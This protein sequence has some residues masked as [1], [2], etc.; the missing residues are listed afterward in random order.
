MPEESGIKSEIIQK[1]EHPYAYFYN[2]GLE[3]SGVAVGDID[4]DGLPDLFLAS[5]PGGNRLYRQISPLKFE[6][7]TQGS[8]LEKDNAWGRGASLVDILPGELAADL[9]AKLDATLEVAA[10]MKAK[11]DGGEMAYDQMLG[12][13]NDEGNAVLQA[14]ID[15]L[16][17]QTKSIETA[18][19]A[20]ELGS[21]D[22]EGSD[23]LDDPEAV[24][25]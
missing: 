3:A 25:Q 16:V 6:D 17:E 1:A 5:S 21:I 9:N 19:A 11:A 18:V 20:L 22:F 13:G 14:V 7:I 12:E 2:S 8:G 15:G 24:F 10:V 4:R 23:S